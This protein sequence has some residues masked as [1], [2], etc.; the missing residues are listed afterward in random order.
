MDA[1][2]KPGQFIFEVDE[3]E[4]QAVRSLE[5]LDSLCVS[6]FQKSA[7]SVYLILKSGKS[8]ER[9]EK[10]LYPLLAMKIPDEVVQ[11]GVCAKA[12][13]AHVTFE[14]NDE[15]WTIPSSQAEEMADRVCLQ[16]GDGEPFWV[17]SAKCI[18]KDK[19]GEVLREFF[20]SRKRPRS[21]LWQKTP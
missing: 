14:E 5:E 15:E 10:I 7:V 1:P 17:S 9:W 3:K 20:S 12:N 8:P 18:A 19:A 4:G 16:T 6:A 2:M 11:L 21:V 13:L